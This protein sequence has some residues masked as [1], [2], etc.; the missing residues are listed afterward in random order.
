MKWNREDRAMS[1]AK[2]VPVG[3]V[4][5]LT[6]AGRLRVLVE[7]DGVWRVAIDERRPFDA[8][9]TPLTVSHCA[10]AAGFDR[11]PVPVILAP[12]APAARPGGPNRIP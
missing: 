5:L 11:L 2:R 10:D 6:A 9:G 3:G 8:D 7:L 1:E 4:W 12:A